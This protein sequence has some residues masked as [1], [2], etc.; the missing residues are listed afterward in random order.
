MSLS[1]LDGL[2]G[3]AGYNVDPLGNITGG[4]IDL[5][6]SGTTLNPT[7]APSSTL[8]PTASNAP[9]S[10]TF[11]WL[12]AGLSQ[13]LNTYAQVDA[14][15]TN[16]QIAQLQANQPTYRPN[17]G[18]TAVPVGQ[19]GGASSLFAGGNMS[20]LLIIGAVLFFVMKK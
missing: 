16:L 6:G 14:N 15:N 4:Y 1:S 11:D 2:S 17:G 7:T 10:S 20:L 8:D 12:N 19:A 18:V 9:P 5:N 13:V 3:G